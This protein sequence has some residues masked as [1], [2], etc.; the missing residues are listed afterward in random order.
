MSQQPGFNPGGGEREEPL[1][2]PSGDQPNAPLGDEPVDS[3]VEA[4]LLNGDQ[5]GSD[6]ADAL[7]AEVFDADELE[8]EMSAVES[9]TES[10]SDEVTALTADLQ[11]L[12]AEYSNYKKRVDRDRELVRERAVEVA[13]TALLPVLD[14]LDL[15][16]QHGELVG[17]FRSVADKLVNTLASLGLTPF[18]A[19]GETFDPVKHEALMREE[20]PAITE[21]TV[22]RVLQTGYQMAG[23]VVRP[24]RVSVAGV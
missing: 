12:H 18:G 2:S 16:A 20:D 7:L 15:A 5:P 11:R 8:A 1:T 14:D 19:V 3:P 10:V 4:E 22:V 13:L 17:G 24:A 23:R 9:A 6:A 21:P